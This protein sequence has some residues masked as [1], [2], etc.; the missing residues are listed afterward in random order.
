MTVASVKTQCDARKNYRKICA[1]LGGAH[2]NRDRN[3][4]GD[5]RIFDRGRAAAIRC[6]CAQSRS[7]NIAM[8]GTSAAGIGYE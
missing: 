3:D 8:S 6:E 2:H 5:H 1:D 7:R 4:A